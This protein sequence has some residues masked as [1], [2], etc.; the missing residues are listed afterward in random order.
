MWKREK[1]IRQLILNGYNE[2]FARQLYAEQEKISEDIGCF[3]DDVQRGEV[4]PDADGNVY[5]MDIIRKVL[6]VCSMILSFI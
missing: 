1:V 3:I 5:F 2:C 4:I 6:V